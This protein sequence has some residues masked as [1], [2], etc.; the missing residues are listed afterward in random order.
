[1]L[2]R[3]PHCTPFLFTVYDRIV[4]LDKIAEN[5]DD[6]FSDHSSAATHICGNSLIHKE[7]LDHQAKHMKKE[8]TIKISLLL[9]I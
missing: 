4:M 5:I 2:S 7:W 8:D 3:G 1:M 9:S 6:I